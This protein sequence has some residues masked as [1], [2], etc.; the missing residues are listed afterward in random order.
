MGRKIEFNHRG[1]FKGQ[2]HNNKP[3]SLRRDMMSLSCW[4]WPEHYK[5]YNSYHILV[6]K[7]LH[8]TLITA[9]GRGCSTWGGMLNSSHKSVVLCIKFL[10]HG[11][12]RVFSACANTPVGYAYTKSKPWPNPS[13]SFNISPSFTPSFL[14]SLSLCCHFYGVYL[15]I[16]HT[17]FNTFSQQKLK[18][19]CKTSSFTKNNKPLPGTWFQHMS[20]VSS[21]F[22]FFF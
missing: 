22:S 15:V 14:S 7:N 2:E 16:L 1:H 21:F 12:H 17:L 9:W 3:W 10:R 13:D 4:L 6:L 19:K 5:P 11:I 8:C 20:K 18:K